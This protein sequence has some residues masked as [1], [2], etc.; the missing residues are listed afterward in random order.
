MPFIGVGDENIYY[1]FSPS[2]NGQVLV[3]IHGS[4]GNHT[5]WPKGF[6]MLKKAAVY[7]VDLPGHGQ[8]SGQGRNN[9]DAYA[10]FIDS[11]VAKLKL[12]NVTLIGH[13][14]GGAI[15]QLLALLSPSVDFQIKLTDIF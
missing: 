13:S 5:H 4:G 15:A 14:L 1:D 10:D 8:S 2:E 11:F 3:A 7:A 6:R 9:V 12:K